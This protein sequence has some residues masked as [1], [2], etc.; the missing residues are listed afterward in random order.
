MTNGSY[1][2]RITE[3][4]TGRRRLL[5]SGATLSMGAAALA[6]IGCSN[7]DSG[8]DSIATSTP[9]G[10]AVNTP[11]PGGNYTSWFTTVNNYNVVSNYQDGYHNTGITVFDRPITSR[12]DKRGYVLEAME[13]IEVA[14]PT[15]IVLTLKPGMVYHNKAPVNGRKVLAS[16]IVSTQ[17]YIK[18]LANAENSQF[19]RTFIDSVEAPNET[20]VVMKLK[21]PSAYLFS[22]TYLANA[23]AQPIVPKEMLGVMDTAPPIGSGPFELVDHTFGQ[24]YSYKKFENFREAKKGQPYFATREIY[25]NLVDPVAQEAA[26]RSGQLNEWIPPAATV[27]RL[28]KEVDATK[29]VNSPFLSVASNGLAAM[30]NASLGGPRPW[31]DIRVREAIYRLVVKQPFVELGYGNK[32]VVTTGPLQ[33][34]L[35][36]TYRIDKAIT[37]KAYK[38]DPAMAKQLLAASSFDSSKEFEIVGT[39]TQAT[40]CA[41]IFA[42]Q[43]APAGFKFRIQ[44]VALAEVLSKKMVP[45]QFDLWFGSHPGGDT[46]SGALRKNHSNTNDQFSNVGLFNKEIDALIEKSEITVDKEENIKQVR[47]ILKRI[48]EQY[49]TTLNVMTEQRYL[50]YDKRLTNFLIDPF[51]GQDY[52]YEAWFA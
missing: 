44:Q 37:D 36:E 23:T 27:D 31:H 12:A 9:E 22:S 5:K 39:S 16:D 17:E 8:G 20:T 33:Q 40:N 48:L 47:D 21:Q 42:Q 10:A 28:L 46:P 14:E 43:L 34:G 24:K 25:G 3:N 4:R 49:T 35:E 29:T 15:R 18:A 1:W 45:G 32:A 50:F 7:D 13:K 38:N 41:E 51:Y 11:K 6:L 30:M 2:E 26:F 52:Q 19:Q